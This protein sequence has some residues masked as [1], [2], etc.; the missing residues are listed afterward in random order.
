MAAALMV[1]QVYLP[2]IAG[3]LPSNM[4]E[5]LLAFITFCFHVWQD[6]ISS[7]DLKLIESELE[8]FHSLCQV[9]V[10][11]GVCINI[12]LPHQHAL[13]HYVD[14]I[15]LFGSPNGLCSSITEAKHIKSVKEPWHRSSQNNPLCE[16]TRTVTCMEKSAA[17]HAMFVK[18]GMLVGTTSSYAANCIEG[19]DSG[20]DTMSDTGSDG[21]GDVDVNYDSDGDNDVG[22]DPL[23]QQETSSS[24]QL[25]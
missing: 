1:M 21:N 16:M 6:E 12:S 2:A 19:K 17:L 13:M 3:H 20:D 9:F 10:D 15:C 18:L 14:S 23:A 7:Q 11:S 8:R 24:D 4:V 22:V 25:Q 5:C